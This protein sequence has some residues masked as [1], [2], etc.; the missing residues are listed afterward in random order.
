LEH[1][2]DEGYGKGSDLIKN[3]F[4]LWIQRLLKTGRGI[5]FTTHEKQ[6]T[7]RKARGQE[8][9]RIIPTLANP[10]RELI[11]PM[12]ALWLSFCY[13]DEGERIMVLEGDDMIHAGHRFEHR[14]KG[15]SEIPMG[16]SPEEAYRNLVLAFNNEGVATPKKKRKRARRKRHGK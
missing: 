1:P 16:E 3:E 7:L 10:A 15:I 14:F 4:L 9:T 13:N 6:I 11:E 12:V 8:I 5:I 2:S